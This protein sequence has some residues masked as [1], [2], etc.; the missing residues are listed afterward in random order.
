MTL[1][2]EVKAVQN[3]P[4]DQPAEDFDENKHEEKVREF[5]NAQ[6]HLIFECFLDEVN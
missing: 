6:G 3:P 5:E 4:P 2:N 1:P